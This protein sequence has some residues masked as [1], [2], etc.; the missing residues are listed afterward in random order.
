MMDGASFTRAAGGEHQPVPIEQ[1]STRQRMIIER[2][3]AF[4]RV[5]GEVCSI[6][7]LARS[8]RLSRSTM[9]EHLE[10]LHRKGWLRSPHSPLIVIRRR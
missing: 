8:L 10:A 7:Q 2:I 1:L 4:E 6:S 3:D 5:A 9:K